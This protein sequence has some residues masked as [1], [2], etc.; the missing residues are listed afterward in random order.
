MAA[1]SPTDIFSGY[2]ADATAITIPLA[3][4]PG[5]TQ[6]EAHATTGD[7]REVLRIILEKYVAAIEG[8]SAN[9]RPA[10]MQMSRGNLIGLTPSLVRRSYSVT[11][12]EAVG[13]TATSLRAEPA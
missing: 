1:I 11:F 5:L 12:E 8:M 2:S 13:P 6:A 7:A 9:N 3:A 4:L 10:F